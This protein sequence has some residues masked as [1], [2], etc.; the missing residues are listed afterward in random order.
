MNS[1]DYNNI[2]N[3]LFSSIAPHVV[4]NEDS[5]S[6]L[7]LI[8]QSNLSGKL[9][10]SHFNI[11]QNIIEKLSRQKSTEHA[12]RFTELVTFLKQQSGLNNLKEILYI[13]NELSF[14]RSVTSIS[15]FTSSFALSSIIPSVFSK[16]TSHNLLSHSSFSSSA[17]ESPSITSYYTPS[18]FHFNSCQ[19]PLGF[20]TH[21]AQLL[22]LRDVVYSFQAVEG[23][24]VK[25]E[26]TK[27]EFI[28]N[29]S[30]FFFFGVILLSFLL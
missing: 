25:Y 4:C 17:I 12:M 5:K 15:P 18:P 28:V 2:F 8:F 22:L 3:K 1:F 27:H 6:I 21:V 10:I 26:S 30:V 11:E 7:K 16:A 9:N 13:L 23:T 24:F 19:T 20:P 29:P 14:Q